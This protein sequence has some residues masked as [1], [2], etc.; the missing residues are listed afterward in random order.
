M[1]LVS[2]AFDPAVRR[3]SYRLAAD[4]LGLGERLAL[5]GE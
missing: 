1:I 3:R 2:T 5:V 4:A